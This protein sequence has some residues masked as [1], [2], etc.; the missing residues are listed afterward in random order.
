MT[1]H[2]WVVSAARLRE[3]LGLSSVALVNDFVAQSAAVRLLREEDL[4]AIGAPARVEPAG[5]GPQ[6]FA[7]LGPGTG[8]GVGALPHRDGRYQPLAPDGS[9]QAPGTGTGGARRV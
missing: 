5:D 3:A 2:P 9:R 7:V 1:N 8:L 6:T 4:V